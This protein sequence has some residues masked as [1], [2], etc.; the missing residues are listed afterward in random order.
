MHSVG[1][2]FSRKKWQQIF[3]EIDLNNDDLVIP[4]KLTVYIYKP[5]KK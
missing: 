1:I 4:F 5:L 3:R 2:E